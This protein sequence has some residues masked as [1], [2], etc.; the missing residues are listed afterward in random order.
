MKSNQNIVK[1]EDGQ[2]YLTEYSLKCYAIDFSC[3]W[4]ALLY[5]IVAAA[6]ALLLSC[7]AGW[8]LLAAIIGAGVGAAIGSAMCGDMAAIMR[9]WVAIKTDAQLGEHNAVANKPGV[10][11]TCRAFGGEITYVPNVNNEFHALV[12]FAG[13]TLMTGLEGFM[14]VYAARGVGMLVT[15][16]L[17]FFANFGV[18][19]LKTVSVAGFAG[20]TV[21]GA[22]GGFS[23]YSNSS[24][25]GFHAEEVFTDA[26][27]SFGFAEMAAYNALTERD[28]QSI[29]LLLSLGGIPGGKNGKD[30]TGLADV[31]AEGK[32]AADSWKTKAEQVNQKIKN[33]VAA[34]KDFRDRLRQQNRGNGAHQNGRITPQHFNIDFIINN[35]ALFEI[36]GEAINRLANSNRDNA[37]K[38]YVRAKNNSFE[39]LTNREIQALCEDAWSATR[40][41]MTDIA[42]ENG[43][44][45][46]GEIHHWNYPKHQNPYDVLN[47]NQLT[48]PISRETHQQIHEATT[49]NPSDPWGGP[50]SP[51]HAIIPN[52]FDLPVPRD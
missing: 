10:H 44:T 11:M 17:Q 12:L 38:R 20:R 22:W 43:T 26:G 34:A 15:K 7:P 19:Y 16:P 28:P 51:D 35:P 23:S 46:D 24:T 49:S 9:V 52:P 1:R 27:K 21:F 31:R 29:A 33:A 4:V 36:F 6:M 30:A 3:K 47:P 42:T 39:G 25:E 18:N 40:S 45:I 48:D 50:I 41:K 14:Y 2:Y 5:A 37:Y 13:N 8:I 32:A